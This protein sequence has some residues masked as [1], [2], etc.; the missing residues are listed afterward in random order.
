VISGPLPGNDS[1]TKTNNTTQL[2]SPFAT[3]LTNDMRVTTGGIVTNTGLSIVGVTAGPG[4]IVSRTSSF[5]MFTPSTNNTDTFTYSVSD[6]TS[7]NN[8][9]VTVSSGE[10]TNALFELRVD[11]VGVAVYDGAVTRITND[12]LGVPGQVYGIEYKGELS[13]PSWT[14]AGAFN[15][16]TN[17]LSFSVPIVKPGNHAADW[18]NSMF[19]RG[20]LTNTNQ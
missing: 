3:L 19:F 17:Q 8:A 18:N 7:T 11:K 6:G 4:N 9:T 14:T 13:E 16:P 20:Y 2:R 5:V 12:F 1:L 10:G 15:V